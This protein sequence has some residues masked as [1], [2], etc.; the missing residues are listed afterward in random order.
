M[1]RNLAKRVDDTGGILIV[2]HTDDQAP[3]IEVKRLTQCGC[4]GARAVRIVAGVNQ[5]G[6]F[7]ANE[8]KSTG[9]G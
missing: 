2:Q 6:G 1:R 4:Q 3:L 9:R 8:L 7:D 5:D